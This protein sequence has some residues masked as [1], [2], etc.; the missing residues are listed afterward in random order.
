[1]WCATF[2]G[3]LGG[4]CIPACNPLEP[5]SCEPG[6]TCITLADSKFFC[7]G[8]ASGSFGNAGIPCGGSPNE[9]HFGLFCADNSA[10]P[11]CQAN[12]GCCTSFCPLGSDDACLPGQTCVPWFAPNETPPAAC[13]DMLGI[14]TVVQ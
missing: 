6:E 11:D 5:T 9:C 7:S 3:G 13:W 1:M 14:C 2:N 12:G 4:Y 10:F 8:D